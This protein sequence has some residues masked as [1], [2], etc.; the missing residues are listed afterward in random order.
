MPSP[1]DTER[2][3]NHCFPGEHI[4]HGVWPSYCFTVSYRDMQELVFACGIN[5]TYGA[6]HHWCLKFGQDYAN[7]LRR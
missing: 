5:V 1:A 4:S 7:R 3:T 2:Y 6:I